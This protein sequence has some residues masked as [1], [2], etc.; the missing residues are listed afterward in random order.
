MSLNETFHIASKM[1]REIANEKKTF[2]I[3]SLITKL[4]PLDFRDITN[5]YIKED[6]EVLCI[7]EAK[8]V[9]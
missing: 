7:N 1:K 6:V 9:E 5:S 3:L 4:L 8:I 2:S